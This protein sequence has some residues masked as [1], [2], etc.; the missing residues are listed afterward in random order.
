MVNLQISPKVFLKINK[1]HEMVSFVVLF[2]LAS[3]GVVVLATEQGSRVK[4]ETL[5]PTRLFCE[6]H[7]RS[8]SNLISSSSWWC[9]TGSCHDIGLIGG[10]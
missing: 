3:F 4:C 7:L 5:L 8:L 6:C 10:R 2:S 1:F 9:R